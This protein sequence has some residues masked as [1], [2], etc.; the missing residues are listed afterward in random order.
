[1]MNS[2]LIEAPKIVPMF[3]AYYIF[4]SMLMILLVLHA[5]WTY[6]ILKIAVKAIVSG[7]V[8]DSRSS[9]ES[10]SE[11]S[12]SEEEKNSKTNNKTTNNINNHTS[13]NSEIAAN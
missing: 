2:T 12:D 9:S 4:N 13:Q 3:P 10:L 6:Y 5:F 1:V 7:K 8:E 11:I